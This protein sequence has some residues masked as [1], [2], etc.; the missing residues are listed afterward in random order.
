MDNFSI[1]RNSCSLIQ[2]NTALMITLTSHFTSIDIIS[3]IH[4][5]SSVKFFAKVEWRAIKKSN[6]F[7]DDQ[8]NFS[9]FHVTL[10][11]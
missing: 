2:S 7:V 10:I 8:I 1:G 4:L 9:R 11:K 3:M 6:I 5:A